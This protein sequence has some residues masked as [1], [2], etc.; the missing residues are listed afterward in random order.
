MTEETEV[1]SVCHLCVN[2]ACQKV[3][4]GWTGTGA[5]PTL[6]MEAGTNTA[7]SGPKFNTV[8][9]RV[10]HA[11]NTVS[12]RVQQAVNMVS[13]RVQQAVNMVSTRVQQAVNM[14]S[15]RVRRAVNTVSTK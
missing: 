8:S 9:T 2:W 14:V 4:H 6:A 12:T 11:V 3:L 13:T 15:T 7:T 5:A 1:P 10:Q